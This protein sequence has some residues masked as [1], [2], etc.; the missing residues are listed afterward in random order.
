M[1][2]QAKQDDYH[3]GPCFVVQVHVRSADEVMVEFQ[4]FQ[5]NI[6]LIEMP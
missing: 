1:L 5:E 6:W 4:H 2:G 3:L